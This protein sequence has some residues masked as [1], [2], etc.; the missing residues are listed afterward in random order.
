M[1]SIGTKAHENV[2]NSGRGH[3]QGV[4]KMYGALRGHLCDS[5]AFLLSNDFDMVL[6]VIFQ[7]TVY[8]KIYLS[9]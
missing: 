1:V 8:W 2:G 3:S 9:T 5:T 7:C 4:P 6:S